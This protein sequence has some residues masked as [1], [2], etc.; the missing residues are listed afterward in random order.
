MPKCPVCGKDMKPKAV[1]KFEWALDEVIRAITDYMMSKP[2]KAHFCCVT[3][4]KNPEY[5]KWLTEKQKYDQQMQKYMQVM[6]ENKGR[7]FKKRLPPKPKKLRP[8]PLQKIPCENHYMYNGKLSEK[9]N[10]L[11]RR[12]GGCLFWVS[13]DS[14]G[15]TGSVKKVD[16]LF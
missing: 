8:E 16:K 14:V 7:I 15:I 13:T 4:E 6:E 1:L 10:K 11:V 2:F 9:T 12:S 5:K 3:M